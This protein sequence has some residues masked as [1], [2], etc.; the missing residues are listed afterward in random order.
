MTDWVRLWHDMPTDPKW[1][2]IARK[3]GQRVGDV[4]ALFNFL[5]V[6]ASSNVHDRGSLCNGFDLEDAATAL[7]IDET[8]VRSIMEAMQGKVLD[9]QRLKGWEKR[10]PKRE[11]G[12]AAERKAA[13]KERQKN[14]EERNG[15]QW[16]APETETETETELE[17]SN[18]DSPSGDGPELRPEHVFESY[19]ALAADLGLAVPRDFTPERRQLVRF[20]IG[21]HPLG[22]FQTVMTRC[23]GSPFLRGD[24]G[25]TPL[26]FD[27][28]MQKK[29][30]QKVLEGNY[31]QKSARNW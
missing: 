21:Q 28:L 2:T 10:Q 18:D 4:I 11:D 5:M 8:D 3:S 16:N 24:K 13:W 14:A 19:Q 17:S 20:R 12:T 30:F 6:C 15:T 31:E 23:R 9:G 27:W 22:D 1:R 29:N 25:R 26:T 7:D